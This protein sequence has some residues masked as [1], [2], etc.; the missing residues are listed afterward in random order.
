LKITLSQLTNKINGGVK[1]SRNNP[2]SYSKQK[3]K[4][5]QSARNL[6]FSRKHLSL[7]TAYT[8]M[9]ISNN[10]INL[11]NVG[12][13]GDIPSLC[14]INLFQSPRVLL[15]NGSKETLHFSPAII[16]IVPRNRGNF[17]ARGINSASRVLTNSTLLIPQLLIDVIKS[18]GFP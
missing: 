3:M 9:G 14:R 18:S 13:S 11:L 5:I 15:Q 10:L 12:T 1:A 7:E 6:S 2:K 17:N 16:A 4:E 8:P